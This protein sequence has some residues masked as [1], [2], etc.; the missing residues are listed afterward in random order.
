MTGQ[1]YRSPLRVREILGNIG[2]VFW[3]LLAIVVAAAC[4]Y[5]FASM[6]V[7]RVRL[8]TSET[9]NVRL[10]KQGIGALFEPAVNDL[11]VLS[12]NPAILN[13]LD[14]PGSANRTAMNLELLR[15]CRR[16][17]DYFELRMVDEKGVEIARV[18]YNHGAPVIA[19]A[20]ELHDVSER[21]YFVRTIA[22]DRQEVF[23]SPFELNVE[24]GQ[25]E[26]PIH[27]TI[28]F[29][30]PV[31]DSE[32]YKRGVL[33]FSYEGKKI[34]A[35]V[36]PAGSSSDGEIMLLNSD[37]Y[38]L[39]GPIENDDWGFMYEEKMDKTLGA[40]SPA[41]W[42]AIKSGD[43]GK[44]YGRRGFYA[45]TTLSPLAAADRLV[46]EKVMGELS[47]Q[48]RASPYVWKIAARVPQS[49]LLA[50]SQNRML[51]AVGF[52]AIGALILLVFSC[53]QART[54]TYRQRAEERLGV[55]HA[56]AQ[57]L[58]GAG[59]LD[60]AMPEIL[61]TIGQGARWDFGAFWEFDWKTDALRC[62]EVWHAPAQAMEKLEVETRTTVFQPRSGLP[63]RVWSKG[64]A[65]WT[66]DVAADQEFSRAELAAECGLRAA[67]AVP[68]LLDG[69][70]L[71]VMEFFSREVRK[72]DD[73]L[74]EML[75]TLETQVAQFIF[76]E[77]T[78]KE[79]KKA[80]E[81]AEASNVAKS[82]FLANMSHEI[83]TPMN[84]V[85][86]MTELALETELTTEQREYLSTAKASADS[87]LSLLN[88]I[89][90]FSK[91]EA[92][93]LDMECIEFGL[94]ITLDETMKSLSFR[95]HQKGLE[96]ACHVLADVPDGLLGDP[97]R[98]R[99]VLLNLAGNAIKFT[100]RGE[101]V[102]RVETEE[103]TEGEA[104][105]HF[106][107][108]DTGVGVPLE[109]Q[110]N[111]FEAFTQADSSMTRKYGGT[112]LGLAIC[113]RLVNIMG[114][115]IWVESEPGQGST[116]HFR[117]KFPLQK[118]STVV[119]EPAP[120]RMLA[121]LTVLVVDDNATNR[122]ILDE[123]LRGWDMKPILAGNANCGI[124]ILEEAQTRGK[125]IRLMLLDAQMPEV[126]GFTLAEGMKQSGRYA[127]TT[128]IM[129]TS[130]GMR[131]DAA[132]CR[133][134]GIKAYLNKPVRRS[135]LL[136]AILAVL[137]SRNQ[138]EAA[139]VLVTLHTLRE[140]RGRLKILLAEDNAVN[141]M[142]A[143]RL[144]EKRGHTVTVAD[145]GIK[146]LELYEE[147]AFDVVLMDVQMPEMD[148]L[149]ATR[150]IRG[151]EKSTG[152]H[153]PIIAMT[154]HAMVGDIERCL[155]SG[156]D[157]YISKPLQTKILFDVLERVFTP[158]LNTPTA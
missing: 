36:A 149:E 2:P 71:G 157:E 100:T 135:D 109:K 143:V 105:L 30:T 76:R 142:L 79:L 35:K 52:G 132:R 6:K 107:V 20:D 61:R 85:I 93:K 47:A 87:L 138:S 158:P 151:V 96:L 53:L 141:Q 150:R 25:L 88:D 78:G 89:L 101:V 29:S 130:G 86:G 49:T 5:Y 122:R 106:S 91:I 125:P 15:W 82:E 103:E 80:K 152:R 50:V 134:L 23:V 18:N 37:G 4:G 12:E 139:P 75:L 16:N 62:L 129:L 83:R 24:E 144:L 154:A 51:R 58:A 112:G 156:M 115:K 1:R 99:Q 39:K 113:S 48:T 116:F 148:G 27:P 117:V 11:L 44:F 155:Q 119:T 40:T 111:I 42:R 69:V 46:Y 145:T 43:T 33:I 3:L 10:V 133:E 95:A 108:C 72:P 123:M 121:G 8:E 98:L 114:G 84:G 32:G 118:F 68:I 140:H 127:E 41:A 131:G 56:V 137:G 17:T 81:A 97:T 67:F 31:F 110:K 66:R 45:F 64:R 34:L 94:R 104:W 90:D 77:R 9:E 120:P 146:A 38:W 126:D 59:T 14:H 22:L 19:P 136:D 74:I 73:E 28:L 7:W 102:V 63:G 70:V 54:R 65:E 57:I 13:Y 92:G 55:H 21:P 128:A 147:H 153:T 60:L 26:E 124:E